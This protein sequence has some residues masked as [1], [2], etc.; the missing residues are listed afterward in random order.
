MEHKMTTNFD[1][2]SPEDVCLFLQ[3]E[4]PTLS[5]DILQKIVDHKIDGEVFLSLNDEYLREIAPLLGDR[6]KIRRVVAATL[7]KV[8][9]VSLLLY[10]IICA[11]GLYTCLCTLASVKQHSL[12]S[13]CYHSIILAMYCK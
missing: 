13:S 2:L 3:D 9:T 4:I 10:C 11:I 12:S 8:S 1:A 6:L 7:A 5:S